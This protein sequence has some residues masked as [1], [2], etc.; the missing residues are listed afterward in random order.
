MEDWVA[1]GFQAVPRLGPSHTPCPRPLL[2]EGSCVRLCTC[3]LWLPGTDARIPAPG[4]QPAEGQ[5]HAGPA[6]PGG[7]AWA[8]G[9]P[10]LSTPSHVAQALSLGLVM[11][12]PLPP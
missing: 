2:R 5:A 12:P 4:P 1:V 6:R 7:A 11:G 3:P 9:S 10:L 8:L